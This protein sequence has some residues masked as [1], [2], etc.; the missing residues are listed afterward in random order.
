VNPAGRKPRKPASRP[1]RKTGFTRAQAAELERLRQEL[2]RAAPAQ[3]ARWN[4]DP[5][6]VQ[7]SVAQLVLTLVEFVRRMLER[8][9]IRRMEGGTLSDEQVE[10]VG[11]ALMKLEETVAE[12]AARF[13]IAPQDLQLELGPLGRLL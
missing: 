3:G 5:E 13:G 12:L 6:N 4:P 9:A 2:A 10:D 8:Q 11:L 7:R 1:R